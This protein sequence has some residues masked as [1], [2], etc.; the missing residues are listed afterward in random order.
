VLKIAVFSDIHLGSKKNR[1]ADIVKAL[2]VAIFENK[3]NTQLDIIFL[4]GDVFDRLLELNCEEIPV[5]DYWITRLLEYCAKYDIL[6]RVLE[7]TPSHEWKQSIRFITISKMLKLPVNIQYFDNIDIEYIEEFNIHV[8]YIPDEIKP[9]TEETLDTVK[10]LLASRGISK[11]D[12]AIM[13]GSM[14]YQLGPGMHNSPHHSSEEYLQLVKHYIFI[15]H[16]HTHSRYDRII[17]QGSFDRLSHGQEEPKGYVKAF[18]DG[19]SSNVFFIENKLAREHITIDVTGMDLEKSMNHIRSLTVNL[20]PNACVRIESRE[21]NPLFSNM[22]MLVSLY[23]TITWSKVIRDNNVVEEESLIMD[24][25]KEY[26]PITISKDNIV[27]LIKPRLDSIYIDRS[28]DLLVS[29]L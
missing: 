15:G 10:E 14:D 5:I 1:A 18:V 12:Y 8:L 11:V 28:I 17:A 27:E 20:R 9:T 23:P 26:V 3:E 25:E 7:G 21:D 16:I 2:D 13:H 22:S 4:A 19:N 29:L 6:L 24:G